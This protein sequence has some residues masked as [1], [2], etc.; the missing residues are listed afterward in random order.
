MLLLIG[1]NGCR[2]QLPNTDDDTPPVD[3]HEETGDSQETAPIET[4]VDLP[5]R[6]DHLE[7][8]PNSTLYEVQPLIM[9]E[10]LCG[11]F[12]TAPS[13]PGDIDF[14]SFTTTESGWLK[15][16]VEAA[17]RGTSADAQFQLI[18]ADNSLT[19]FDGYLTT[20]PTVVVPVPIPQAFTLLLGETSYLCGDDYG[21]AALVSMAK[22][23]VEWTFSESEPNDLAVSANEFTLG[24]TVFGTVGRADD[25]DWYHI[26]TPADATSLTF[27]V[28]AFAYGSPLDTTVLLY[29][30]DGSTLLDAGYVGEV[31][32]DRDPYFNYKQTE[33][34][35]WYLLVKNAGSGGSAY[36]WYT[37]TITPEYN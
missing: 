19:A 12:Q 2:P 6:C 36:H 1:C 17:Q 23:P 22:Q 9:E 29:D 11:G 30:T 18:D 32:Y 14:F 35:D 25:Y 3:T 24:G 27:R 34:N 37:L 28:D 7:V 20:D 5:P 16:S 26:V 8:E 33:A 10:W 13:P 4:G 21:W 31:D 15:V